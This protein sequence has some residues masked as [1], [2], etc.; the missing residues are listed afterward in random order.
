ML[1]VPLYLSVHAL[2]TK[3]IFGSWCL[4]LALGM[5]GAVGRLSRIHYHHLQDKLPSS[6][7]DEISGHRPS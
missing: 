6:S 2:E 3:G 7:N 5:G 1:R 4:L